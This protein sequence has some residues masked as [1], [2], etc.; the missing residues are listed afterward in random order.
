MAGI[1]GSNSTGSMDVCVLWMLC[2]AGRGLCEGRFLVHGSRT[3]CACV[4]LNVIV[5]NISLHWVG[6]GVLISPWPDQE[7]NM[8]QRQ[9]ILVF[10]YPIYN[11]N[12]RYICIYKTRL[13]SNEIFSPSNKI[14]QE[15]GRAKDLSARRYVMDSTSRMLLRSK[16]P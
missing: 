13:A 10:V 6:T 16:K 14:H 4:L 7:G 11:H 2:R 5:C 3:E 8:L 15:V 1:A 12:W 9:K